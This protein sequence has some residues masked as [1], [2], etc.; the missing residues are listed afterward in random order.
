MPETKRR[1]T[2]RGPA[3][4]RS[5]PRWWGI[6][7]LSTMERSSFRCTSRRTWSATNWASFHRRELL[8]DTAQPDLKTKPLV[9]R[10]RRRAAVLRVAVV[11]LQA[12]AHPRPRQVEERYGQ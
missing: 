10:V 3:A 1:S 4:R 5:L 6:P 9:Q 2:R 12:A 7:W 11:L 8:K